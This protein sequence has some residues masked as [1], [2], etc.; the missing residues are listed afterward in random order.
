MNSKYDALIGEFPDVFKPELRHE[1]NVPSK[2]GILHYIKTTGRPVHS[3]FRRLPPEKLKAAKESF[4]EMERMG[5]CEKG[6][7]PWA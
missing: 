7:S 3:K 6:S 5:L 4:A 2:H 1:P